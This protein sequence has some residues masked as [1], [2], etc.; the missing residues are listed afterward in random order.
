MPRCPFASHSIAKAP[1]C[2]EHALSHLSTPYINPCPATRCTRSLLA[3]ATSPPSSC[4]LPQAAVCACVRA[5]LCSAASSPL[6]KESPGSQQLL[7]SSDL[8]TFNFLPSS[9]PQSNNLTPSASRIY[10][11]QP[12]LEAR[13]SP[14]RETRAQPS[15][16]L[17]AAFDVSAPTRC[18]FP[19]TGV[20]RLGSALLDRQ[21]H[22]RQ[23]ADDLSIHQHHNRSVIDL[24][25][26]SRH[27][28]PLE[29]IIDRYRCSGPLPSPWLPP[30]NRRPRRPSPSR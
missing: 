8:P 14:A 21:Q 7:I 2:L 23:H 29:T 16:P 15:L 3:A 4:R 13:I 1:V 19:D 25:S 28:L 17:Q 26:L 30:S 12:S 27:S 11:L 6:S 20:T 5:A 9:S 22:H 10:R 24:S 18:P